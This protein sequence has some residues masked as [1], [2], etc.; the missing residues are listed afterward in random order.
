VVP[1]GSQASS[2][3]DEGSLAARAA[4]LYFV[5]GLTQTEIGK[6]LGVQS[7]KAHRLVAR[8]NRDGMVRVHVEA[9]VADCLRLEE[10]L[11]ERFRLAT[12]RVAP[13]LHEGPLPLKALASAGA[14]FLKN[15]IE[16]E[17]YETIGVGN[18]RTLAALV[19]QLPSTPTRH[20][21][22]VSVMGG[23]TRKF[24]ANPF[25]VIH[26][27]AEKTGAES[28][29]MPGPIFANSAED[30]AVLL[31]QMGVADAF[32]MARGAS[33][34]LVG[35]GEMTDSGF[36]IATGMI[37]AEERAEI[38]RAKACGEM[39][40][41]FFAIDGRPVQTE[42]N[43]RALSLSL[44]ELGRSQV[45]AVAGGT[46]KVDAIL[47]VLRSGILTGLITDEATAKRL[48]ESPD[49]DGSGKKSGRTRYRKSARE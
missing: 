34:I 13:D 11:S 22:F 19:D 38:G 46:G 28:Y 17:I 36:L 6:R 8:A 24:A 9:S 26:R 44:D 5:G 23:L 3:E 31:A 7:T 4:W 12:C 16:Q 40:G 20:A 30:K 33:L 18:G 43:A 42:L 10:R 41:H 35:I 21:R 1:I 47:S 49:Q 2:V 27:L 15:A 32:E 39:L 45:I 29:L 25:D 37:R 14:L 48:A